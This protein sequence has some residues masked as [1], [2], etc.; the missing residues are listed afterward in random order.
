MDTLSSIFS[1]YC[2]NHESC[3]D[4]IA[5]YE[6]NSGHTTH[7]VG[8][9]EPNAWGL[10]DMSGNVWEWC[11]DWYDSDYYEDSPSIDPHGPDSGSARV[12]RGGNLSSSARECRSA[13]R[14]GHY[15]P[16]YVFDYLGFRLCLP[17]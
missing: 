17:Q 8:Q 2:G 5:W 13:H 15:D 14:F 10:Y 12:S 3:L 16:S 4:D 11:S 7:P 9:K 6:D 1:W